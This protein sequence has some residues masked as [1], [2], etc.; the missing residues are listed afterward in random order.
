MFS[1]SQVRK[2]ARH[3]TYFCKKQE[4]VAQDELTVEALRQKQKELDTRMDK[5][6]QKFFKEIKN[7]DVGPDLEAVEA[8]YEQANEFYVVIMS[9]LEWHVSQKINPAGSK[10]C[11][12]NINQSM[13]TPEYPAPTENKTVQA[14]STTFQ[15]PEYADPCHHLKCVWD[16]KEL[17]VPNLQCE[18]DQ[19]CEQLYSSTIHRECDEILSGGHFSPKISKNQIELRQAELNTDHMTVPNI[20]PREDL[21]DEELPR[22]DT[23]RIRRQAFSNNLPYLS[24]VNIPMW[25][26]YLWK[27]A[28][29]SWLQQKPHTI[30]IFV[31]NR[32]GDIQRL[33]STSQWKHVR[34]KQNPA[35]LG[36]GGCS[37]QELKDSFLWWKGPSWL[38]LPEKERPQSRS[39]ET[40]DLEVKVSVQYT[41]DMIAPLWR[42]AILTLSPFLDNHGLLRVCGYL[43]YSEIS[44]NACHPFLVSTKTH[45][46]VPTICFTHQILQQ[47]QI[48]GLRRLIHQGCQVTNLKKI[49]RHS[50][51]LFI[52]LLA[53]VDSLFLNYRPHILLSL[54][55]LLQIMSDRRKKCRLCHRLHPPVSHEEIAIRVQH[56]QLY[57]NSIF[58]YQQVDDCGSCGER[59]QMLLCLETT[60]QGA[61]MGGPLE[62]TGFLMFTLSLQ[63]SLLESRLN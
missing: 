52:F 46:A 17:E 11:F 34:T 12:T 31:A 63:R 42:S 50:K 49:I 47:A 18:S 14:F 40:T 43:N 51:P 62:I 56:D 21:L 45:I 58:T 7:L 8:Q 59:H 16:L 26:K 23:C 13:G 3:V 9:N 53:H 55:F 6:K 33:V 30:N 2:Y 19:H 4:G 60:A 10:N 57:R 20:V 54:L 5:L 32:F 22:L 61:R 27:D 44:F 37:P 24:K 39:F 15:S 35:D 25:T 48:N 38:Q 41:V 28:V 1:I 29:L 36:S